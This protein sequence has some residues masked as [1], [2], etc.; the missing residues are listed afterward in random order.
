MVIIAL[1]NCG[2]A[3]A[4]GPPA[5]IILTLSPASIVADGSSKTVLAALVTDAGGNPVAASVA[6]AAVDSAGND[7]SVTDP[8]NPSTGTYTWTLTSTSAVGAVS[9]FAGIT[10]PLVSASTVLDQTATSSTF[11]AAI[12]DGP[13]SPTNLPVTNQTI[14]LLAT[15]TADPPSVSP[16]GTV[17]FADHGSPLRGCGSVSTPPSSSASLTVVCA[18]SMGASESPAALTATFTPGPGTFVLPSASAPE[19]FAIERD[20]T[21]VTLITGVPSAGV[22]RPVSYTALVTPSQLGPWQPSG[23]VAFLDGGRPIPA[24][25]SRALS[26]LGTAT[27]TLRYA[28]TGTHSISTIYWGDP[29]FS[30]ATSRSSSVAIEPLGTIDAAMVWTFATAPAST[31]ILALDVLGV[32]SRV[33]IRV[34]CH[35]GGCP[36]RRHTFRAR[37]AHPCRMVKGRRSCSVAQPVGLAGGFAGHELRPGTV[38]TVEI[39]QRGWVGKVYRFTIRRGRAPHVQI[40]CIA[41][42]R[43][44]PGVGC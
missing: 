18:T 15:V 23:W 33:S 37:G 42:G 22:G 24:C 20:P 36:F 12:T 32:S 29:S 17:T 19:R 39:T 13:V 27:C 44:R 26:A 5:R 10:S 35:G 31:G 41:P 7:L 30:G 16:G 6:V 34:L 2:V 40:S 25:S 21:A 3:R 1:A 14:T 28:T 11:L 9:V 4:S 38:I 43:S 8:Q